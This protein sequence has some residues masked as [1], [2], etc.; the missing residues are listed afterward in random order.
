MEHEAQKESVSE[1]QT[2]GT[3]KKMRRGTGLPPLGLFDGAAYDV[4]ELLEGLS[5]TSWLTDWVSFCKLE[6]D[7][8]KPC[9]GGNSCGCAAAALELRERKQEKGELEEGTEPP[10]PALSI[11]PVQ[12]TNSATFCKVLRA[13]DRPNITQ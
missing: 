2:L 6:T 4:R 12:K 13:C 7:F 8:C 10:A 11:K 5:L 1:N 3:S 9:C